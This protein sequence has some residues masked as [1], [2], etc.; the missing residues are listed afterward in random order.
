MNQSSE[1]NHRSTLLKKRLQEFQAK[2]IRDTYADLIEMAQYSKLGHFFFE[3]IYGSHDFG[4]R[5]ESMRSLHRKMSGILKG[6]IVDTVGEVIE[7]H[8]LSDAL[9]DRM[10]EAM[11]ESGTGSDLTMADYEQ[12]Y[13]RC[14]NYKDRVRQIALMIDC[15]KGVHHISRMRFI[16]FSLKTVRAAAHLAGMGE[17]MEFLIQGYDAFRSAKDIGG[18]TEAVSTRETALNNKLY[19]IE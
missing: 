3:Q 11:L 19:G 15:I 18:F 5:N 4:F 10:V 13:R 7:L 9:D 6:E 14:N 2:R 1:S 16:G 17:I 12:I 8:D